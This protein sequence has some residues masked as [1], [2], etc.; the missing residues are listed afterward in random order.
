[1]TSRAPRS[2]PESTQRGRPRSI[3]ARCFARRPV[4]PDRS[5]PDRSAGRT[6][7]RRR[8]PHRLGPRGTRRLRR[9]ATAQRGEPANERGGSCS[10]Q[11]PTSFAQR[12]HGPSAV[13]EPP[14]TTQTSQHGKRNP[15]NRGGA[16]PK[17]RP[18]FAPLGNGARRATTR[19]CQV[20]YS[21]RPHQY[22][23]CT[24]S[25]GSPLAVCRSRTNDSS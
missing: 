19:S 14:A 24:D 22:P 7:V 5:V 18:Q 25:T 3:G 2:L 9:E 12:L 8:P 21:L 6:P 10:L 20:R 23:S 11:T 15:P 16:S 13:A 17:D 4:S 1:V